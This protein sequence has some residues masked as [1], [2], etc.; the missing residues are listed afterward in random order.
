MEAIMNSS[1]VTADGTTHLK[2]L[3]V[4]LLAGMIVMW[5]GISARTA[6]TD[7]F[8]DTPRTERSLSKPGVPRVVP[9][10]RQSAVA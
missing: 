7:G 8:S 1:L 10:E 3:I 5:I 4:S 6:A 9:R 2:I